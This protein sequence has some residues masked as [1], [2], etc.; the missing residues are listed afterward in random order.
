MDATTATRT[1]TTPAPPTGKGRLRHNTCQHGS[2]RWHWYED[3]KGRVQVCGCNRT[4]CEA[5]VKA[6][7]YEI[8]PDENA[9]GGGNVDG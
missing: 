3:A 5:A 1:T 8:E 4:A 9:K 7:G 6:D 2:V